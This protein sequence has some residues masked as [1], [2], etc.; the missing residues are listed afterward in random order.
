MKTITV[1]FSTFQSVITEASSLDQLE[2]SAI[3]A[4]PETRRRQ[5]LVNT[6]Q[7]V[8]YQVIP[9][10]NTLTIKAITRNTD[11]G[12]EYQSNIQFNDVIYSPQPSAQTV[13]LDASDG[14]QYNVEFI[15]RSSTNVQVACNCLDFY[16]TFATWNHGDGSLLG[17]KPE[18]YQATSNRGP[19]NPSRAPGLCKHLMRLS[20]E[21]QRQQIVK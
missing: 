15:R 18:P 17:P 7:I 9:G 16:W 19:R 12:G 14:Q 13:V 20:T 11:G 3:A 8:D 5:H 10:Q 6:I 2:R 4:F 21:L 1:P